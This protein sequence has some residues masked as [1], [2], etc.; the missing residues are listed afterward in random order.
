VATLV[1]GLLPAQRASRLDLMTAAG[2]SKRIASTDGRPRLRATLVVIEV[3]LS[4]ML[5][6]AAALL[7][8]SFQR[9]QQ[10]ELGFATDRVIVAYTQ[11]AVADGNEADIRRRI[12]FYSEVLDRLRAVP[13]VT[14]AAG[15]AIL[16]MG[17]QGRSATRDVFVHGRPEGQP[18]TR[19][20]TEVYAITP[21]YFR[22]LDIPIR[23]G[24]D[25][26][27]SD[28]MDRPPV[29]IINE[30]LAR[31]V[32]PGESPLGRHL[33]WN[34]RGAWM[35]IVGVVADTRWQHPSQAPHPVL[36]APTWQG[37]GTSPSILARTSLDEASLA[38]TLRSLLHEANPTVPVRIETM[39]EMFASA[40]AYPRFRS[41]VVGVFAVAAAL[42]ATVGLFSV[43]AYVVSQRTRE[44]A[45]RR[46][47]GARGS[48]VIRLIVGQGLKLTLIG[49]VLGLAAAAALAR[50]LEGLL[51]EVSPWDAGTYLGAVAVLGAA[52]MLAILLPAMRAASIAPA[53]VLQQE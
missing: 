35:E 15:V 21:G 38:G 20:T 18:G 45:I 13:G 27:S 1:F 39:D 29:A 44:L 51:Y 12:A 19:P 14:S 11:Y 25:F 36:F 4:V 43:L 6:V 32:F 47:V 17:R 8:R 34:T 33:R 37:R 26:A 10:V 2:G 16:P 53:I 40:L 28:S 31:T 9:L 42:L 50:L 46:A 52:A 30:A 49:L 3:A 7:L 22:T 5:V 41:Q 48:D 24:R 23:A